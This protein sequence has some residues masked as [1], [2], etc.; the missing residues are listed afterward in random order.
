MTKIQASAK[1]VKQIS[2][3]YSAKM[4]AGL[5]IAR[6]INVRESPDLTVHRAKKTI[7]GKTVKMTVLDNA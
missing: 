1:N 3:V 2:G 6:N 7:G 5:T 4:N